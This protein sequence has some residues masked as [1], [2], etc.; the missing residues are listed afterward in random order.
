MRPRTLSVRGVRLRRHLL[1]EAD[2]R[3]VADPTDF[4]QAR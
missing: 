4:T 2:Y 3:L 1:S